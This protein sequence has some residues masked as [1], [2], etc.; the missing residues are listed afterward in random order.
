MGVTKAFLEVVYF[1]SRKGQRVPCMFNPEKLKI[2]RQNSWTTGSG[3][4]KGVQ[5][6]TFDGAEPATMD[7]NLWFDTTD[8]GKSVT[9]HTD[10][11]MALL[12]LDKK[13]PG[14]NVWTNNSRPPV[15]RFH[16]GQMVSFPA[17]IGKAD[18]EFTYFSAEGVPLRA[19]MNLDLKQYKADERTA[20]NPTSGTPFPH[21]VHRMLPGETLDRIAAR[22]YGDS[23]R[24]RALANA[25]GV[26]DPLAIRPG[27]LLV[28][29]EIT[30]L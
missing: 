29:P 1:S 20:Q 11:I 21:R 24:W 13:V 30:S 23:N 27:S 15:V 2:T 17:V 6:A 8:T 7:L 14:T 22:Y 9:E 10:K 16:W 28:V 5:V 4:G 3:P 18:I 26:E 25:N 12:E 19:T